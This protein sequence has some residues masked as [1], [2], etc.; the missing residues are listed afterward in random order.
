[1][2]ILFIS[3]MKTHRQPLT[4]WYHY[5][6][7]ANSTSNMKHFIQLKSVFSVVQHW[8][9]PLSRRFRS[10]K[11]WFVMRSFGLKNLQVHIR[12][13]SGV[14]SCLFNLTELELRVF[15]NDQCVILLCKFQRNMFLYCF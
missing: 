15:T 10:L 6:V 13:V 1:M 7:F 14:H 12:H 9:I 3:G 4:L 5:Y 11:L 8:Q 2:L